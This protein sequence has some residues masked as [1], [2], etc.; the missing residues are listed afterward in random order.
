[1]RSYVLVDTSVWHFAFVEPKEKEFTEIHARARE[2]LEKLLSDRDIRI[3]MSAY[4]VG[5]VVEVLGRSGVDSKTREGLIK[6][7][8]TGKFFVKELTFD[9]VAE[10]LRDSFQ[11]GIHV[12]DYLVAYPLKGLVE[13]IYS[14]DDHFRHEHFGYAEVVNP[15]APWVLREGVKPFRD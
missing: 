10:A 7:F 3:A 6:D 5:E 2:A 12:Y 11:S 1:M 8:G 13:R 4:Q 9:A 14:A 15:V